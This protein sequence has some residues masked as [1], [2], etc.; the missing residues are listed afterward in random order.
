MR[1]LFILLLAAILEVGGDALVRW[2]LTGPQQ[3]RPPQIASTGVKGIPRTIYSG[4]KSGKTIGLIL[5]GI[6]L[7]SYGLMVNLTKLD[8]GKLMGIYIVVF[9]VVSQVVAVFFF[10]EKIKMPLLVGGA[11][12]IAGGLVLTFWHGEAGG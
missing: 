2:G 11:L 9:F 6:V 12:I 4:F 10:Q 5:G 1:E 8:F 3:V 7:V